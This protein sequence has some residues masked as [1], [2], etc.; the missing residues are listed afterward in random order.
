[1]RF[2]NPE[3]VRR[4]IPSQWHTEAAEALEQIRKLSPEE[5]KEKIDKLSDVWKHLKGELHKVSHGKCWYCETSDVR[6]DDDV[7]HWRPK[8]AVNECKEHEGYW[9]LAFSWQNYRYT[10][11]YCNQKRKKDK[12]GKP[13]S[14]GKGTSF[15][16]LNE[17]ERIF[18]ECTQFELLQEKPFLLDPMVW[19]DTLLIQFDTDG[20]AY[21]AIEEPS[22]IEYQRVDKSIEIYHL[23]AYDLKERRRT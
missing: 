21:S 15:P 4:C 6:H 17:E 1:M 18:N 14:G 11:M 19:Q 16:L 5:R 7:D 8:N 20:M 2:I 9:W 12:G 13:D 3:H 22:S 23:N 10:C